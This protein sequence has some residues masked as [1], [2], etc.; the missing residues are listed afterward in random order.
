MLILAELITAK[1]DGS[2]GGGYEI[3]ISIVPVEGVVVKVAVGEVKT[4]FPP[5]FTS[6]SACNDAIPV[7][8]G[9]KSFQ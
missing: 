4:I 5:L 9:V 6:V 3:V 8:T 2:I 7:A 1:F